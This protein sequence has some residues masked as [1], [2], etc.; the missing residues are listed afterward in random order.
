MAAHIVKP[1][2]GKITSARTV[3]HIGKKVKMELDA[4]MKR[5]IKVNLGDLCAIKEAC[6]L[7]VKKDPSATI[8]APAITLISLIECIEG[9]A[10]VHNLKGY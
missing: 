9:F 1:S 6:K 2:R 5:K 10:D 3:A 7:L 4:K 8:D